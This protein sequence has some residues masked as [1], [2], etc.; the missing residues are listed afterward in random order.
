MILN[1]LFSSTHNQDHQS[2][3]RKKMNWEKVR[4]N[5]T[6]ES[7]MFSY[8]F[9]RF[10]LGICAVFSFMVALYASI[11]LAKMIKSEGMTEKAQNYILLITI[12]AMVCTLSFYLLR[13][14]RQ[15]EK[16]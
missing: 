5:L 2:K 8:G 14:I 13:L 12:C 9:L 1:N 3:N 7:Y 4:K 11:D 16:K 15:R 6:A 10:L